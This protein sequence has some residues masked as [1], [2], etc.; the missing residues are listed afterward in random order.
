MSREHPS[1]EAEEP[2][3]VALTGRQKLARSLEKAKYTHQQIADLLGIKHRVTVTKL[4]AR[5]RAA[6]KKVR[7]A[8]EEFVCVP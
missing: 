6:E 5:A 7:K 4:L 2:T 1:C 8:L 3:V